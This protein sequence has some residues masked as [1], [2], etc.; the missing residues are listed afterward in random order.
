MKPCPVRPDAC[1][2][3]KH[4]VA[5]LHQPPE[6][7]G[8]DPRTPR[9]HPASHNMAPGTEEPQEK[10]A[11]CPETLELGVAGRGARN[12]RGHSPSPGCEAGMEEADGQRPRIGSLFCSFMAYDKQG[13]KSP[14][15]CPNSSL[16]ICCSHWEPASSRKTGKQPQ[17]RVQ[18][19]LEAAPVT[20]NIP[21]TQ[22]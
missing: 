12:K 1:L 16:F 18:P 15:S 21:K 4:P 17:P 6:G 2:G 20:R 8:P 19:G 14:S 22:N 3:N 7:C 11:T 10:G 9:S 5:E 13:A